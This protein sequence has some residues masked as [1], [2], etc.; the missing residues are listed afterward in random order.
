[1]IAWTIEAAIEY[2]NFAHI[3]VSTDCPEIAE[4]AKAYGASV[5][6]LRRKYADDHSSSSDATNWTVERL[7]EVLSIEPDLVVQLMA[8]IPL[9]GAQAIADFV[10]E[11]E[12]DPSRSMISCFQPKFGPVHW[13]LERDDEGDGHFLLG[14][15]IGERSQDLPPAF[16][17]SGAIWGATWSYL[18]EHK[19]FY[20]PRFR[21]HELS[22]LEAL[23]IDTPDELEICR[24]LAGQQ[25]C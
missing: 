18:K 17:P 7:I 3:V 9:R 2:G 8:N 22:W 16:F 23:D 6:F 20:G 12:V 5:P 14:Q 21:L 13:A 15:F 19:S 25:E 24:R 10:T 4:V 11:F 1:M